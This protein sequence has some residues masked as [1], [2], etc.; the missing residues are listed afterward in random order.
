MLAVS[1]TVTDAEMKDQIP[2][3]RR[4]HCI[5]DRTLEMT[6]RLTQCT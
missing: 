4:H 3:D 5:R 2:D 1:N 6:Q